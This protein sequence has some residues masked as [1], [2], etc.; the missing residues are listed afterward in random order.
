MT[1][2]GNDWIARRGR[3]VALTAVVT[4]VLTLAACTGASSKNSGAS[5]DAS[6]PESSSVVWALST[7]VS[8]LDPNSG[9]L[10]GYGTADV[11]GVRQSTLLQY[12]LDASSCSKTLT[13][14]DI[15]PSWLVSKFSVSSDGKKID[16]TLRPGVMSQ[17]NHELTSAD[18]EWSIQR[19]LAID[20]TGTYIFAT[21]G[22][23]SKTHPI[24]VTD[25]YTFTLNVD[26]PSQA[27]LTVLTLYWIQIHDSTDAKPHA[28]DAD[29]WAKGYVST[30]VT[31][32]GP[33]ALSA[34]VPNQSVVYE[35][36]PNYKGPVGNIKKVT[37]STI[38]DSSQRAQLIA[39]GQAQISMDLGT[40]DLD[41]LV[42]KSNVTTQSCLSIN[43]DYLALNASDPILSNVKV[44]QAISL[45]IDRNAI[46]S[47]VYGKYGTPAASGISSAFKPTDGKSF[48]K[49]DL[50]KAKSLLT[51]AGYP[52]GFPLT[53]TINSGNPGPYSNSI[54]I[55]L[56]SQLAKVGIKVTIS[57]AASQAAFQADGAK[58]KFQAYLWKETPTFANPG[59]SA[60]ISAGC[61]SSQNYANYCDKAL[62]ALA[63][64]VLADPA[65]SSQ[66]TADANALS[67]KMDED[68]PVVYL[69]DVGY[70]VPMASCA[71]SI[72]QS[73][74]VKWA[75]LTEA[76]TSC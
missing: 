40:Q 11:D 13:T 12:K 45:A 47:A 51:E 1:R 61:G 74:E 37:F 30:H 65:G 68:Q 76:K 21:L 55:F 3:L 23:F 7:A 39:T 15:V 71:A 42:G 67:A 32:F 66:Y 14:K 35:R 27:T 19:L 26:K 44:R 8:S 38:L 9:T 33:W 17:S 63:Q 52:D 6:T 2:A 36:N 4:S 75:P 10:A 31:D 46:S 43:R 22:G 29:P 53:L 50:D 24:D 70:A 25:K 62:D 20:P 72:P 54:A 34:F 73:A 5:G 48:E 49:L 16:F 56:Q 60:Q 18:V 28:T 57:P 41:T 69:E 58:H 64:Q 59:L